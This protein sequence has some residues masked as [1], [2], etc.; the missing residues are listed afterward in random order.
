MNQAHRRVPRVSLA[1]CNGTNTIH[2]TNPHKTKPM[3][4]ISTRQIH[5]LQD[6]NPHKKY[7]ATATSK[8]RQRKSYKYSKSNQS[9]CCAQQERKYNNYIELSNSKKLQFTSIKLTTFFNSNIKVLIFATNP[10]KVSNFFNS[11][12]IISKFSYCP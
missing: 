5:D 3:S 1:E 9:N 7:Q 12:Y 6:H 11:T 4:I 10:H 8:I 2:S